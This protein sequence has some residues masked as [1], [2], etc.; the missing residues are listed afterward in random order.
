VLS[1]YKSSTIL[2]ERFYGYTPLW[3]QQTRAFTLR[4]LLAARTLAVN[5]IRQRLLCGVARR[6]DGRMAISISNRLNR[7]TI[8]FLYPGGHRK[9]SRG[10]NYRALRPSIFA[11]CG[12]GFG[13]PTTMPHPSRSWV[14][15]VPVVASG[16]GGGVSRMYPGR[17]CFEGGQGQLSLQPTGP[18]VGLVRDGE[19][20]AP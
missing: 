7:P 2:R 4:A 18:S 13:R 15:R 14:L 9:N 17:R 11:T 3:I 8:L 12:P 10:P 6:G 16:L 5:S 1:N 20:T 19:P